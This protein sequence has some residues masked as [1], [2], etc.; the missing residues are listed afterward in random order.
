M[1]IRPLTD[2]TT[3]I[4]VLSF[5]HFIFNFTWSSEMRLHEQWP[6]IPSLLILRNRCCRTFLLVLTTYMCQI[7]FNELY[8]AWTVSLTVDFL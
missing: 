3:N 4:S 6:R 1:C 5:F 2:F 7:R 8:S